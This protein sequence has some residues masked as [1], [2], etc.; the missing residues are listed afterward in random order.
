MKTG[1]CKLA[2]QL[3]PA[4]LHKRLLIATDC[5]SLEKGPVNQKDPLLAQIWSS[6][7]KFIDSGI[8]RIAIEWVPAYSGIT[9]NEF[10]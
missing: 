5:L 3:C 4:P 7:Y 10:A 9:R 8:A 6:L 1:I 2:K